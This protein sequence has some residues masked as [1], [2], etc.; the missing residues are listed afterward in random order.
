[1]EAEQESDISHHPSGDTSRTVQCP[2]ETVSR[3][4]ALSLL[5]H[6]SGLNCGTQHHG[7]WPVFLVASLS[8]IF[9]KCGQ[10]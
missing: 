1:M 9:Y 3:T 2:L 5:K 10:H 4:T 7:S 6:C 8:P